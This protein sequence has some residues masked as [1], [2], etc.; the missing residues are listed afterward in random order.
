MHLCWYKWAPSSC[1]FSETCFKVSL[2]ET[3][4]AFRSSGPEFELFLAEM[5]RWFSDRQQQLDELFRHEDADRSG[6]VHMKD[7]K[8]GNP[9]SLHTFIPE[10]WADCEKLLPFCIYCG[11]WFN[12]LPQ[13][14]PSVSA[15][16]FECQI[17]IILKEKEI[18]KRYVSQYKINA[19]VWL[20]W[21][22]YEGCCESDFW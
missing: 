6:S 21:S 15:A 9:S 13:Q 14:P 8:L 20:Y 10:V 19:S 7:F 11:L 5:T 1:V 4:R 3:C 22:I 12:T 2:D 18:R 16:P 17:K